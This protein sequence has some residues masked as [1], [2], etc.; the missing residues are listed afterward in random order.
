MQDFTARDAA[1]RAI[2]RAVVN[3]QKL[4]CCLKVLSRLQDCSGPMSQIEGKAKRRIEKTAKFT[5]GSAVADWLRIARKDDVQV[6]STRDLFEPWVS[7]SYGPLLGPEQIDA[8]GEAL[9]ALAIE[10]NNLIHH[11]LANFDFAS[12]EACR[13]LL[14]RLDKQNVRILEQL[15]I[16]A[17]AI[18]N[19][20][21][22]GKLAERPQIVDELQAEFLKLNAAFGPVTTN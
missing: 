19:L 1:L 14:A 8:H 13:E 5:M 10:R 6:P 3:F 22:L 18:N 15:A 21:E 9:N 17:P 12:D 20:I 16:L 7:V 2:G 11:D 4:E